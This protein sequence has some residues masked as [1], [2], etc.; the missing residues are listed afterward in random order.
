MSEPVI[1]QG[2]MGAGVSNWSWPGYVQRLQYFTFFLRFYFKV[3]FF[4][5]SSLERSIAEGITFY[6]YKID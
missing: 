5:L 3:S 1:I 2:G 4:P 6:S